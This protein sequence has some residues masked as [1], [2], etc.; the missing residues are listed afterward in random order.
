M[1]A[2]L[3][4]AVLLLLPAAA[5]AAA[6]PPEAGALLVAAFSDPA[7]GYV[8]RG[9]IQAF[10]PGGK[11]KSLELTE[12]H[13]ADGR[14]RR[15]IR[16]DSRGPA[17][18]SFV[19]DGAT[20]RLYWPRLKTAW[21]ETPPRE[22]SAQAAAR[23]ESLYAIAVSDGGRVAR[24]RTWR[25][26]F[27][28]PDGRRRRALWVDRE[29]GILLECEEYR[30]DGA[31]AR[32]ERVTEVD[33]AAPR[34]E[35]FRLDVPPD[36]SKASM[37]A[38]RGAAA[39]GAVFPRWIPDGFLALGLRVEDGATTV[40]YGD[41][42]VSFTLRESSAAGA[43]EKGRP[44]RLADGTPAALLAGDGVPLL[45]FERDGR[46]YRLTGEITEDEMARLADSI[47]G[48]R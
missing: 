26:D 41:G 36:A 10:P 11:P 1:K 44:V 31:L 17:E 22:T 47:V 9:R 23:L 12:F 27:T 8:A 5:R 25:L 30:L 28:G 6:P 34:P 4:L 33:F 46:A 13:G 3:A 42:V 14:F 2:S 45:A 38:P 21:S 32:R 20:A 37:T 29:S 40:E 15:D 7:A 35:A 48:P 18:T 16:K 19:D 39:P 24:R 43:E